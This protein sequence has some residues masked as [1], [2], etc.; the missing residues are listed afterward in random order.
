[1]RVSQR[2]KVHLDAI[3]AQIDEL[4]AL[5][6]DQEHDVTT[7]QLQLLIK[8]LQS[9][10]LELEDEKVL[11][12][13]A[14]D[15]L[16]LTN[17]KYQ[18]LYNNAP[19]GYLSI[20]TNNKIVEANIAAC[21]LLQ[22]EKEILCKKTLTSFIEKN[23]RHKL[24]TFLKSLRDEQ[25][26]NRFNV[27]VQTLTGENLWV[28]LDGLFE[29]NGEKNGSLFHL[30]L[31]DITERITADKQMILA[32]GE[33]AKTFNAIPDI[34][35]IIDKDHKIVN[36]N[37]A[38]ADRLGIPI[39]SCYGQT[40]FSLIHGLDKPP[41]HCPLLC[42]GRDS[43]IHHFEIYEKRLQGH[44]AGS[45]TPIR[46]TQSK[47]LGNIIVLHD[48]TERKII[49]QA[50]KKS[51]ENFRF[52]FN[53]MPLGV[54]HCDFEGNIIVANETMA[55]MVGYTARELNK[56]HINKLF[57]EENAWEDLKNTAISNQ[58]VD[59][60]EI[61]I[62]PKSNRSF[63][64]LL[65]VNRHH[66]ENEN[67]LLVTLK[68]ISD[69]KR[70]ESALKTSQEWYK[71]L[72]E[73]ADIAILIDD[74]NGKFTYYN[75]KF[76]QLF[77]YAK[78]QIR[79][80]SISTLVHP[81]DVD[82][83]MEN[84][85]RRIE[86]KE[87]PARYE[88][89][90][91]RSDGETIFLEVDAVALKDKDTT[92]GSLSYLWD[93]TERKK[94]ESELL[95]YRNNLEDLIQERTADLRETNKKL[96]R[97][98]KERKQVEKIVKKSEEKYRDLVEN[99][100][101]VVFIIGKKGII[102]YISPAIRTCLGFEPSE[103]IGHSLNEFIHPDELEIAKKNYKS[104]FQGHIQSNKYRT[105]TKDGETRWIHTSS[106]PIQEGKSVVGIQ[107]IFTDITKNVLAEEKLRK[108][109]DFN[110]AILDTAGAFIVVYDSDGRIIQFNRAFERATGYTTA[111]VRDQ[112][113]WNICISPDDV[114]AVMNT[115]KHLRSGLK[116]K[117]TEY[118]VM[119]KD[120]RCMTIAWSNAIL[121]DI[122]DFVEAI[123]VIG[124]D[125][126]E[127]RRVEYALKE[128][129][130]LAAQGRM[131]A[132]IAHEINN[133]LGGIKNS[134][135]LVKTAVPADH[136]YFPYMGRMEKEVD[137]ITH[138]VHQMY[139]MYRPE[140]ELLSKINM[141]EFCE[142]IIDL[143][144][145][146]CKNRGI[147]IKKRIPDDLVNMKMPRNQI[148]Q[149]LLNLLQNAIDASRENSVVTI[150]AIEHHD[151]YKMMVKDQG[152]GIQ[153]EDKER[154]FEPF[155]STKHGGTFVGLGL[156][157]SVSKSIIESIGGT[158]GFSTNVNEGSSFWFT[159]PK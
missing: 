98:I 77:G 26:T 62:N 67:I 120:G 138:I 115:F 27:Q 119:T 88:F 157:L 6:S 86:G 103:M 31:K 69:I 61:E 22:C 96:K 134:I 95:K 65:N 117:E 105:L 40:C 153:L 107:G 128:S 47:V 148:T 94:V 87:V 132:G 16:M 89:R 109:R 118:K 48:I 145:G 93:I 45:S 108:E 149:V 7:N 75:S 92:R 137:R 82:R 24:K 28:D 17:D 99:L 42:N 79:K 25:T 46:G 70:T 100:N 141:K 125:L 126:T 144:S 143:L 81:D 156:G 23:S 84:H 131:A 116:I 151:R 73:K 4:L 64:A 14:L 29:E 52:L 159:I 152:N 158:I 54:C 2:G 135:Q 21:S 30:V 50:Q 72:V 63:C 71:D 139:K 15:E 8:V 104:V 20:T 114:S 68:D 12:R 39:D 38:L 97:E 43:S 44:F 56:I 112:F 111:E 154:I 13:E 142:E 76:S 35:M 90:G 33:W 3:K 129:E 36:T 19:V 59:N 11:L 51:E 32:R 113:I 106:R 147:R 136:E 34:I 91:I 74:I 127:K 121:L 55:K 58:R 49:E 140:K 110:A 10:Q 41:D 1:M 101:E 155:Y 37:K 57:V 102:T 146:R 85:R 60:L 9:Y 66:L 122:N 78:K 80:H 150:E 53:A 133:P 123:V 5:P 124:I 83:V 130:K 18:R